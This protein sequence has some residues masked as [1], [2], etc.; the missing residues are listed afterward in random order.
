MRSVV[1]I[2]SIV[3]GGFSNFISASGSAM[4]SPLHVR[5]GALST[6]LRLNTI[7]NGGQAQDE[8]SLLSVVDSV[9]TGGSTERLVLNYGDRFGKVWKGE[10]GFFQVA[11][12]KTGRRIVIDLS[13]V[14]RTGIEP[15]QLRAALAKSKFVATT[16]MTMDP[17]D[18]TTNLTLNL[19]SAVD[20]HL[21]TLKGSKSQV[22][23]DLK[24]R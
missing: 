15:S 5:P 6:P 13:Q 24:G 18:H 4:P 14:T 22:I 20:V 7:A 19:R 17:Q 23:L 3:A 9:G 16:D 12:E 8:F 1:L 2:M 21:S 10:P 11:L